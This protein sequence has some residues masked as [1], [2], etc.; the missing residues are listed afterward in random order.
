MNLIKLYLF[1]LSHTR[2]LDLD[3]K[4]SYNKKEK[5]QQFILT[6]QNST[7]VNFLINS[8]IFLPKVSFQ[9]VPDILYPVK[10]ELRQTKIN[11]KGIA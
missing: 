10:T 5:N 6:S 1:Y 11:P 9:Q 3:G 7:C 8:E 4:D 2:L